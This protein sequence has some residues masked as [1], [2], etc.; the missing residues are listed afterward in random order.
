MREEGTVLTIDEGVARVRL[1]HTHDCDS[2]CA[3]AAMAQ[4]KVV[5]VA[6]TE[7]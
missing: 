5:E 3:C 2:C 6:A 1:E 4:D 7:A